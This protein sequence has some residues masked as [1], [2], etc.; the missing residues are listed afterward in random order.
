MT[1][2]EKIIDLRNRV[3]KL[4]PLLYEVKEWR[5]KL[6][7]KYPEYNTIYW[8]NFINNMLNAKTTDQLLTERLEAIVEEEKTIN[9]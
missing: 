8:G 9:V 6:I 7:R 3:A 2:Q 4:K 1:K 5:S